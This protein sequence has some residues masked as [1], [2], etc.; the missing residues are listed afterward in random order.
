M[1]QIRRLM[2]NERAGSEDVGTRVCAR[3]S[4]SGDTMVEV[5]LAILILGLTSV[6]LLLAFGTAITGSAEHRTQTTADTVLRTATEEAT[7]QIQQAATTLSGFCNAAGA[8]NLTLPSGYS[9]SISSVQYW[10][11]SSFV[12]GVSN[13]TSGS[14]QR[15]TVTVTSNG[16]SYNVTV[17]VADPLAPT[18]PTPGAASQL[19][20]LQTPGASTAGVNFVGQPYVEVE[21]SQGNIVLNDLSS[22][23]LTLNTVGGGNSATL[24]SSCAAGPESFGVFYFS[25]CS[26]TQSGTYTLTA[27]DPPLSL[28]KTSGQFTV[29]AGLA[30]QLVFNPAS[31][32]PGIAGSALPNVSA[33]V[34]DSFGNVATTATGSVTLSIASG[35]QSSFISGTT[36]VNLSGGIANFSDLIF[37]K[38]G[39][40]TLTETPNGI[41][42]VTSSNNSMSFLV[43]HGPVSATVSTVN[44]SPAS[45][46]ADGTSTSTVTVTL[47]DAFGNPVSGKNV[48]LSQ[49]G[50]TSSTISSASGSSNSSGVVTFTVTD[51]TAEVVTYSATDTSD[52]TAISG[53]GIVTFKA[54]TVSATESSVSASPVSVNANGTAT[55][56]ITVLLEDTFGNPVSGKTV[57][58]TQPGSGHSIIGA[59]SGTSTAGGVVTFIVKDSTAQAVTYTATDTSDSITVSG[60]ARVIFYGPAANP[61]SS[62]N[63]SP[64]SV[65]ANGTST[66]TISVILLDANGNA[67][68]GK[69]VTLAQTGH[70]T[71]GAASGTSDANGL[72]TFTVTDTK[73]ETVTYTAK[74]TTDNVTITDTAA[75]L[76]VP[77]PVSTATST[78]NPSPASVTANGTLT[79]TITVTL[80]DAQ[81]NPVSGK[82]VALSQGLGT[83]SIISGPSGTS[84]SSGVVTF[85]ATDVTAESVTY[86]ATDTTDSVSLTDTAVVTFLAGPVTAAQ[87]QVNS[88]PTTVTANGVAISTIT[89][90]LSDVEGNP[91]SGK[92]VTLAQSTGG[93]SI[94]G[95]ASGTSDVNGLV[96]FV[97]KDST[98]ET[99]T[100]TAKDTTD[101]VTIIDTAAVVFYGPA[102]AARSQVNSSPTTVAANGAATSTI[103]VNLEDV[104]GN[105]VPGKTVTLA[106]STGGHSIIG[107]ASG[108]SD[109]NGLVTFVV[110]D[111]TA[112]TLTYTA[113]DTTDNVTVTGT[114]QVVFFGPGSASKSSVNPS[115]ASVTANGVATST[116]TVTLLDANSVPVPGK[117]VTLAQ[118]NGGNSAISAASGISSASGVVTFTVTDTTAQAVTYTATDSTDNVTITDTAVVTFT[119]GPVTAAQST[120]SASPTSVTANGASVST[121]TVTL[122]DANSNPVSGKTV[123]L[124]QTGGG[125]STISAASGTSSAS[126]VV[127]FTVKDTHTEA[128]TYTATDSSDSLTV[129]QTA[130]VTFTP[131]PVTAAQSTVSAS[132]TS[133]TANGAS[134]STVT[135]TLLDANSNPVSGKTVTLAQSGGGHSTISAASGTSSASGVVTFTVKDTHTEAL[136]YTA[137]D[138]SDSLTVTQTAVVTFTPGP[139]TAAQSTV[140]ASPITVTANGTAV[141]TVTVTLLDANSN[142]VSGKTV[143]LAQTG[144]GHSTISAASGTS[145]ASGVVTFTVKDTHTE[146]LTY[147]ATDSSDSLTVTQTAVVTFTPGPVTA[148]QST[149]SASPTTVTGSGNSSTITVTLLDANGN[150]V[151]GKTVS[152]TAGSGSSVITGPSGTSTSSGVVTFSVKD[153][154]HQTVTY[155]AKDTTDNVTITQTAAVIFN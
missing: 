92:T 34:E 74:D 11:G 121:V 15:I 2:R 33:Q 133:V 116:V 20:F 22:L 16:V 65:I 119:P 85:N 86:F 129:T 138:S 120:V 91:V 101:N 67:V 98:A 35:P 13:C 142:P 66:S 139:V 49:P 79:S 1:G 32:G 149:V 143:T 140:S 89:V 145:S 153:G 125:H 54:G 77:G 102:N 61:E 144:G 4:E 62:V 73:A 19:V 21:D 146:A 63:S 37:G 52:G 60:T 24:S 69:T 110:K 72:V 137:T 55:S 64:A 127:T 75:V 150:P 3:K 106:Q 26:I 30:T 46:T 118:S 115:P 147:T 94:I 80:L 29:T 36:N 123:T 83:G 48:V 148:A 108:T 131:G 78:V 107:A 130:V 154:T 50:S 12:S 111:S 128:L 45:V 6:A 81:G 109:A 126:G 56:T 104:N 39:T 82:T 57:T 7:T 84:N 88:S 9:W 152:L 41:S 113:K 95:A 28:T 97:V 31:P 23:S 135:V 25:G 47:V 93:H 87:S 44:A 134:V 103:S 14:S 42:G 141:S 53:T 76:F 27:S 5:L 117:T 124:A 38:A 40:Y 105:P 151:S 155:T 17:V 71:I 59:A 51:T 132:P 122:L 114:A 96:T 68:P 100:Y 58:L 136:T 70:S 43:V 10:N 99:V 8:V 18:P 112:E 90:T